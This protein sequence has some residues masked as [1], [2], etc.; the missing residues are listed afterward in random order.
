MN[1]HQLLVLGKLVL[2]EIRE[3]GLQ[4]QSREDLGILDRTR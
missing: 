2:V 1:V 3:L 4:P